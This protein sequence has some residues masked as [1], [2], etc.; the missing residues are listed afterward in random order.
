MKSVDNTTY[1]HQW[2]ILINE[3]NEMTY[4]VKSNTRI[5]I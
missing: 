3:F 1:K 5:E 2:C 4:K